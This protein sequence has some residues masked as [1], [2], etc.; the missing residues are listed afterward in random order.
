MKKEKACLT[1]KLAKENNMFVVVT[2]KFGEKI[3]GE[4]T[5]IDDDTVVLKGK[6]QENEITLDDISRISKKKK[7]N[8]LSSA[9]TNDL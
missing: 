2:D 5:S 4:V 8:Q 7:R 6:I 3:Y 1:L 9:T